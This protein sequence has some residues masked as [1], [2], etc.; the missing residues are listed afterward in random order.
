M[1]MHSNIS[2]TFFRPKN[3]T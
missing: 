3:L 1:T 2:L